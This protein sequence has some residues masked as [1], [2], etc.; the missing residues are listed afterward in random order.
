M[1]LR[2]GAGRDIDTD[3]GSAFVDDE[4]EIAAVGPSM[5]PLVPRALACFL[6]GQGATSA[7]CRARA[8]RGA[9]FRSRCAAALVW[10]FT[11]KRAA[12]RRALVGAEPPPTAPTPPWPPK[13]TAKLKVLMQR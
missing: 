2:C 8:R 10:R 13:A 1:L 4:G 11:G 6:G 5:E 7:T 12:V 9:R 3:K